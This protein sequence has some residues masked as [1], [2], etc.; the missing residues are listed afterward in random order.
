MQEELEKLE[1]KKW[2]DEKGLTAYAL[3]K[4][5]GV[6]RQTVYTYLS[7]VHA[8]NPKNALKIS[9]YTGIPLETLLTEGK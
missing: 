1:L 2:I 7:S 5:A 4:E 8:L 3:A 9:K 6:N